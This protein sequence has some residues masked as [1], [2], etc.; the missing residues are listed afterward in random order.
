MIAP[1]EYTA[2]P[3]AVIW[4]IAIWGDWPDIW[5]WFGMG[6]ILLGGLYTIWREHA[7]DIEVMTSAPMPA[8][9][10]AAQHIDEEL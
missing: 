8:S 1:F 9:A 7:R 3:F 5:S 10:S 2:I 6:L 4:G